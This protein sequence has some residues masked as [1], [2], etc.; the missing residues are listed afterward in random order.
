MNKYISIKKYDDSNSN[1]FSVT[2]FFSSCPHKCEGC[3]NPSTWQDKDKGEYFT[4]E[5]QEDILNHISLNDK[6][7][8]ALVLSG[9]DPLCDDNILYTISFAK[10]FKKRF[11]DKEIWC[12]T[13]YT[14]EL[15]KSDTNRNESLKYID[16]IKCGRYVQNL[17]VTDNVQYDIR[18]ATSN[19]H[20]YK[21]GADY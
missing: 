14:F 7:Y 2:I 13:G 6:I 9:G 19:Q 15:V 11:P 1:G 4:L 12:Y 21:K 18:L 16:Y 5:K 17:T 3:H 20:I 10:E 8:D